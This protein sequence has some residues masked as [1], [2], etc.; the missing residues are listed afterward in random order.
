MMTNVFVCFL[1]T[2]IVV[3][4]LIFLSTI[5][6]PLAQN[7]L[8]DVTLPPQP[9][10]KTYGPLSVGN[11]FY[12]SSQD[13]WAYSIKQTDDVGLILA[14]K[15]KSFG[16][17]GFDMWL[18]KTG[19]SSYTMSNG[20]TGAYQ[21]EKWNMT[22]GGAKDD[23]AFCVIQTFD[24]G[25]AL[26]GFTASF[27]VGGTDMWLV[28]TAS[29]GK[30]QWS[31]TYG[32]PNDDSASCLIQTDDG[33]YVLSGY[34]NSGVQS[35]SAWI[36]KTD[37]LGNM[38]WS[39]ILPG[40]NAN[41]VIK[42][43][44][45]YALAVESL[46]AFELVKVASSGH[47]LA[48][49]L[50]PLSG[51][52]ASTQAITQAGDG[53]YAIVGWTSNDGLYDTWLV[54]TDSTG[55][56][57]WSQTYPGLGG[58]ALIKTSKGGYAITGDRAFLI[59]TDMSGNVQWNRTY[60]GETGDGSQ[61]FTRMQSIIE[62]SPDHFVMAGVHNGGK[63]VNL[64][65]TWIQVALKSGEE[66]I[67]PET[68]IISPTNTTYTERNIPLI[69]YVNEPTRFVGCGVNGLFNRTTSGNITLE[70]LP[71]GNYNLVVFAT[72]MDYNTASSQTVSFSVDSSEPYVLPKVTIESPTDQTYNTTYVD[73]NFTVNQQVFWTAYSLDGAANR[74]IFSNTRIS[75]TNGHH[76]LTIYAGDAVGGAAGSATVNFDVFASFSNEYTEPF[77]SEYSSQ[78]NQIVEAAVQ[79]VT[80]QTFLIIVAAFLAIA[81]GVVLIVVVVMTRNSSKQK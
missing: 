21:R 20:V 14:G 71:N 9:T 15:T 12:G 26:A 62:A 31:Q 5:T 42:T 1:L 80:S 69:F 38:D 41:A 29:D 19:L 75:V 6:Q 51:N 33:G 18:L 37:T 70:N 53:G 49:Q 79:M 61:Y 36:V 78:I 23:G 25:F 50:Y 47:I 34:T 27:G 65:F 59:I 64:Q 13:D 16:A 74:T 48:S 4:G 40:T 68:T 54:K 30:M 35:Q 57:Q 63:C 55:E 46:E 3:G 81:V 43:S 67:P 73:L 77:P 17:G 72:D 24:G 11:T 28:K 60:D 45:G 39:Q 58:Y 52:Q 66:L 44:D 8:F 76:Q 22:Y 56:K 7:N 32:G 2:A 10:S